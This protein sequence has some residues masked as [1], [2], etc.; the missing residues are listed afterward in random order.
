MN[1]VPVKLTTED[2]ILCKDLTEIFFFF[3]SFDTRRVSKKNEKNESQ[4]LEKL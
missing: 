4:P 3:F 1:S 2:F